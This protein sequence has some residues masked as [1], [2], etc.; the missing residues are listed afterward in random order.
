MMKK[1]LFSI[2]L[3]TATCSYAQITETATDAVKNMGVGWNL[4]NTLDANNGSAKDPSNDRYWN[5]QGLESETCWGQTVTK[6][7]L[8]TMMKEAGF[9]A[10]RV[11]VT[12]YNHMD[13]SGKVNAAWMKRV[14]EVVDYVID[15]GMYCIINVHHD[16]GADSD[17]HISWIKADEQNYNSNKERFEYLWKQI[18][19]EF[20][21]YD[22]HLLFEGYNEM[23]D[24]QSTWNEPKSA[25]SYNAINQYAQSFVNAVRATGGNNETRNLIVNTYAAANSVP[26]QKLV[27]PTDNVSNHIIAEVHAYPNFFTWSSTPTLRTIQQVK[28]DVDYI[29]STLSKYLI[30]KGVPAIIGEWGS[31]GVD[32]GPGK[33]D[34][35]LRKNMFLE[36]CDY[37]VKKGKE[38]NVA[39]FYWMGLSDGSYRNR[40]LFNQADLAE[41]ISKAYHGSAF[42]G[43][44][45]DASSSSY[46]LCFE[47]EKTINWGNGI[48]ILANDFKNVGD[49]A[50]L[51]LTYVQ[52][53]SSPD[54]QLFYGDWSTGVAFSVEGKSFTSDFLPG[55]FYKT[56]SGTEHTTVFSFDSNAQKTLASKGLV[57]HGVYATL[58]KAALYD[59]SSITDGVSAVPMVHIS[60][61]NIYNLSGQR[62]ANTTQGLYIKNGK[63]FVVR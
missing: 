13:K 46:I 49:K 56:G 34:Y 45:P 5:C 48:S 10:I 58:K 40:L 42:D 54:I 21:D 44:F 20:K 36:F 8:M 22:K 23:L 47:G 4:G 17:S 61:Q 37:F 29:Y 25:T 63:K 33:T 35:D 27:I 1:I 18:A 59:S 24:A 62:V 38:N 39:T 12:W 30:A 15:N 28:S 53:S 16:T 55:S 57:I 51:E 2:M 9:G 50:V 32:N 6:K 31:Y 7:G 43:K 41:K 26:V 52:T 14:H 11:P 60:D 3:A 19:E